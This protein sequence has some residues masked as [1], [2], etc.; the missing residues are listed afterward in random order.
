MVPDQRV[1]VV[2]TEAM[3]VSEE[4]RINGDISDTMEKHLGDGVAVLIGI[5]DHLFYGIEAANAIQT[6][7]HDEI[8]QR[9]KSSEGCQ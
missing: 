8:T 7:F 5:V 4:L 3:D 1:E 6:S 9:H 2:L